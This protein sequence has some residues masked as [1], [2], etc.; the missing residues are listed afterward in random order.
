VTVVT[1]I[2]FFKT[3]RNEFPSARLVKS[4]HNEGYANANNSDGQ[5]STKLLP[6]MRR[7]FAFKGQSS[8][9]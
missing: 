2:R 1:K 6:A 7:F 4:N 5:A 8:A 9:R 3:R